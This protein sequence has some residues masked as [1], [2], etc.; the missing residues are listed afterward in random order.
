MN[1]INK[2]LEEL[3]SGTDTAKIRQFAK[4]DEAKK[5][6]GA[7]SP[8]DKNRIIGEFLKSDTKELRKKLENSDINKLGSIDAAQL[9]KLLK[10]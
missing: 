4:S 3:L 8:E 9:M 5:I 10:G 1:D 2:K 6:I 7:L